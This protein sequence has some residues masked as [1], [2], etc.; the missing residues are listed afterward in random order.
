MDEITYPI[1]L[2]RYLYLKNIC[3][4]RQAD[5][6]IEKGL[7]KINGIRAILGQKV[8]YSPSFLIL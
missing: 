5:I 6:Y 2:N 3:S 4:R 8:N 1:R 7:I